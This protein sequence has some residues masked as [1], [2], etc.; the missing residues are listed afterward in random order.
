GV[1]QRIVD[2][3]ENIPALGHLS[4]ALREEYRADVFENSFTAVT[5][6]TSEFRVI[7]GRS[8][9]IQLP[10]SPVV[11]PNAPPPGD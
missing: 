11:A 10:D 8:Q 7:R 3:D 6:R 4:F 9:P 5:Q 1:M 2:G